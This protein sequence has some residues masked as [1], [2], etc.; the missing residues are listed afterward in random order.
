MKE[1]FSNLLAYYKMPRSTSP[2]KRG[3]P[4]FVLAPLP[5][6]A[7]VPAFTQP[8]LM[9]TL[10]EGFAFGAG[11]SIARNVID[12]VMP[13]SQTLPPSRVCHEPCLLELKEYENCILTQDS[14]AFCGDKRAS[15][16][17]CKQNNEK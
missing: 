5:K 9:Q 16:R 15:Y 6:V 11:S 8:S 17:D 4:S 7:P 12:R 2:T 13:V 1:W 14:E 3:A 10:K